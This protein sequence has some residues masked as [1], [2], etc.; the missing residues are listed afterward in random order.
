MAAATQ[1]EHIKAKASDLE[2][3]LALLFGAET[4][5]RARVA[6]VEELRFTPDEIVQAAREIRR[7]GDSPSAQ[8]EIARFLPDDVQTALCMWVI[9]PDMKAKVLKATGIRLS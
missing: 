8:M 7:Y 5:E 1:Q 3:E 9:D 2:Q 4:L 6:N